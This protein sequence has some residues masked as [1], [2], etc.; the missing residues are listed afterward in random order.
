MFKAFEND[1]YYQTHKTNSFVIFLIGYILNATD[2]IVPKAWIRL[3]LESVEDSDMTLVYSQLSKWGCVES[4]MNL[5]LR[6]ADLL[7]EIQEQRITRLLKNATSISRVGSR[8]WPNSLEVAMGE[9]KMVPTEKARQ[10]MAD[11]GVSITSDVVFR[12]TGTI[13]YQVHRRVSDVVSVI[14][15]EWIVE[16]CA[17]EIPDEIVRRSYFNGLHNNFSMRAEVAYTKHGEARLQKLK[18]I[19]TDFG[20]LRLGSLSVSLSNIFTK[21]ITGRQSETEA[22]LDIVLSDPKPDKE[23]SDNRIPR[24]QGPASGRGIPRDTIMRFPAYGTEALSRRYNEGL[25]SPRSVCVLSEPLNPGRSSEQSPNLVSVLRDAYRKMAEA[26]EYSKARA[27]A[28]K[29]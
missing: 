19:V 18:S 6:G 27:Q 29:D 5:Q 15:P 26:N 23:Y 10:N 17:P 22:R 20:L 13:T 21:T 3:I 8:S 16:N 11:A 28:L 12:E 4:Q 9:M 24:L 1:A 2:S 7:L 25:S 14:P